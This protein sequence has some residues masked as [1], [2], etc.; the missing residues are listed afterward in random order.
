MHHLT[1]SYRSHEI[2]LFLKTFFMC[3]W[4]DGSNSLYAPTL[5]KTGLPPNFALNF[6]GRKSWRHFGIKSGSTR[7]SHLGSCCSMHKELPYE[8][9][10]Q[11]LWSSHLGLLDKL[12][13]QEVCKLWRHSLESVA[14]DLQHAILGKELVVKLTNT[15]GLHLADIQPTA[16]RSEEGVPTIHVFSVTEADPPTSYAPCWQWLTSKAQLFSKI[17]LT[18]DDPQAWQLRAFFELFQTVCTLVSPAIEVK[19]VAGTLFANLT[20]GSLGCNALCM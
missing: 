8:V 19:L 10:C 14:G 13:C 20:A 4:L 9:L 3:E 12:R 7:L 17:L 15:G 2:S 11:I 5:R 18:G 16:L 1:L 6:A